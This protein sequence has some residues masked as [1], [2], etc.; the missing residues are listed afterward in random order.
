MSVETHVFILRANAARHHALW[1]LRARI[2]LVSIHQV[3]HALAAVL[4]DRLLDREEPLRLFVTAITARRK[5]SSALEQ[6]KQ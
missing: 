3:T 4:V 5:K 1:R 6:E 2:A